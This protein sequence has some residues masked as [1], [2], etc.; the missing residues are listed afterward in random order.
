M[1]GE[2]CPVRRCKSCEVVV[3]FGTGSHVR[4]YI[5]YME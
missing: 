3:T 4:L 2:V 5:L 1:S